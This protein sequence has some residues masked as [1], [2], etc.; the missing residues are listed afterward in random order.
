MPVIERNQRNLDYIR[1][2]YGV[3]ATIGGRVLFEGRSGSIVGT[4]DHY[5]LIKL[6]DEKIPDVFHA[7][8]HMEYV[9]AR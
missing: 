7:T 1:G 4:S 8:W 9:D 2:H 3:P 6:D 5:L